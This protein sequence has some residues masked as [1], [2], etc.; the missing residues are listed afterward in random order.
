MPRQWHAND[1]RCAHCA[2]TTNDKRLKNIVFVCCTSKCS[3]LDIIICGFCIVYPVL[4]YTSK[5]CF[6]FSLSL[7]LSVFYFSFSSVM[8]FLYSSAWI[9]DVWTRKRVVVWWW[10]QFSVCKTDISSHLSHIHTHTFRRILSNETKW[11]ESRWSAKLL[12]GSCCCC[13]CSSTFHFA[14]FNIK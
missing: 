13:C 7:S 11:K 2:T 6:L 8:R 5:H 9:A 12:E 14:I 4:C 1:D 3:R 10:K